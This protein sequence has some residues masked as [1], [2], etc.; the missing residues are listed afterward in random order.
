M[1]RYHRKPESVKP[2]KEYTLEDLQRDDRA[3]ARAEH[4]KTEPLAESEAEIVARRLAEREQRKRDRDAD[5]I[6][7]AHPEYH[8]EIIASFR[9]DSEASAIYSSYLMRHNPETSAKIFGYWNAQDCAAA[10]RALYAA[11]LV[12]NVEQVVDLVR[13]AQAALD[14]VVVDLWEEQRPKA[15]D[16]AL[17]KLS[18]AINL[19]DE[20]SKLERSRL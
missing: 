14:L 6:A 15:I 16:E 1:T 10:R 11:A 19:I 20:G 17:G 7:R 12:T 2:K 18:Q 4:L 9:L 13:A 5:E 3:R 8:R